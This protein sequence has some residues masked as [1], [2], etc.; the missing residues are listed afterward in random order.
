MRIAILAI[1]KGGK[2]LAAKLQKLLPHS[3]VLENSGSVAQTLAQY[4]EKYDGFL[5]IMATGIVVRSIAPL[6]KD[7]LTDPAVVVMDQK[8][9]YSI[10]LLS[11]HLGGGNELATMAAKVS[12]G[13]AVI[14]TA[15]DTLGLV[16]V[17]LW[18]REN[19]LVA[20]KETLTQASSILVNTGRLKVFSESEVRALPQGLIEVEQPEKADIFITH[21]A[22]KGLCFH[23]KNLVVGVGCNRNTPMEEFD[24]AIRE[25][26]EDLS[27][28]LDSV[29][30][31][32]SIDVKNDEVG[33]LAFAEI[34]N[35]SLEYFSRDEINRVTELEVSSAA[36]KAVGA[37]GVAEP[38]A[39]LSAKSSLL[40]SRKRK[41]KNITMAVAQASFTL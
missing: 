20:S 12:G 29:R 22:E 9:R 34:N 40:L 17:D 32:S 26:F 33:L 41:W 11:G 14:T 27:F 23:P 1:T 6:L 37:I 18:A 21:R 25:L 35:W 15:S 16:A 28:S 5:C 39:L 31:L 10:S 7:K 36:L 13:E 24:E 38:T 30:N 8:G 19:A 4:W 2:K 3:Q